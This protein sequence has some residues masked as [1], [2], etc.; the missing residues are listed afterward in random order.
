MLSKLE[1]FP[2][3]SYKKELE[4]N[5]KFLEVGIASFNDFVA[6]DAN[7][8]YLT[9]FYAKFTNDYGLF[10]PYRLRDILIAST[11]DMCRYALYHDIKTNKDGF[12]DI[13]PSARAVFLCKWALKLRPCMLDFA[14]NEENYASLDLDA[15]DCEDEFVYCNEYFALILASVVLNIKVDGKVRAIYELMEDEEFRTFLYHMRYRIVHQDTLN[16]LFNRIKTQE[17]LDRL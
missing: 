12:L 5:E 2:G 3:L 15:G 10:V 1:N 7:K 16:L 6:R 14:E 11:D 4:I 8:E 17:T 9:R 13:S